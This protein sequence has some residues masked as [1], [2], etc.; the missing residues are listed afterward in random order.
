MDAAYYF[1]GDCNDEEVQ[2]ELKQR[3]I[4]VVNNTTNFPS[5]YFC[6]QQQCKVDNIQVFCGDVDAARR[7]R[8]RRRSIEMEVNYH[9]L[10]MLIFSNVCM[11]DQM[12]A[13]K[14][15]D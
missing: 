14:I 8:R 4:T 15:R 5:S 3:Y 6:Q 13:S 2:A 7:R 9:S 1:K 11:P 12:T 10:I